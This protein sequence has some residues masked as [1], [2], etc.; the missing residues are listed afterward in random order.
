MVN[1]TL[2]V[3]PEKFRV[4][5][6]LYLPRFF[7]LVVV[8]CVVRYYRSGLGDHLGTSRNGGPAATISLQLQVSLAFQGS[9]L[10]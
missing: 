6:A 7:I 3:M 9:L 5:A 8:A 10:V 1:A 4:G 2:T